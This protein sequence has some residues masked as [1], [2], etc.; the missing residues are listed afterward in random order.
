MHRIITFINKSV[1]ITFLPMCTP[2]T[3]VSYL[4][5]LYNA[6]KDYVE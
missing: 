5:A 1:L 6:T 4:S 2:F 3:S